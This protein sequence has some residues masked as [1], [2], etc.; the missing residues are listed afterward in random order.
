MAP[1]EAGIGFALPP[2]GQGYLQATIFA[3]PFEND[4]FANDFEMLDD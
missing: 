3:N 2:G 1:D 4:A